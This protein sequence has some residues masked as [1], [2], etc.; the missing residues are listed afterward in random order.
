MVVLCG[1]RG[2]QVPRF[3][4]LGWPGKTCMWPEKND[5]VV[6]KDWESEND[7]TEGLEAWGLE[8]VASLTL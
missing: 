4:L 5:F 8:V 2:V 1:F 3:L 6:F 7:N